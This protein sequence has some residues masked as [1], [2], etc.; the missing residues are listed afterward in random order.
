MRR[1]AF[2]FQPDRRSPRHVELHRDPGPR[3]RSLPRPVLGVLRT[4]GGPSRGQRSPRRRDVR[5]PR[6]PDLRPEARAELVPAR[7]PARRALRPGGGARPRRLPSGGRGRDRPRARRA[8]AR[9][10]TDRPR[11]RGARPGPGRPRMVQ[12]RL[13]EGPGRELDR[14][15]PAREAGAVPLGPLL[16][17]EDDG[18][19]SDSGFPDHLIESTPYLAR[20]SAGSCRPRTCFDFTPVATSITRS[21]CSRVGSTVAPQMIRAVGETFCWTT[22]AHR[23]ASLIVMSVPPVTL[24]RTPWAVEI[25]TS[26]RRELVASLIASSAR[27]S[28]TAWLSPIP[29]IATPPPFMIVFTSLKS[30]FT[31]PGF[32]MISVSPLI[33][34]IRV[35]SANRNARFRDI[36]GT[37][38]RSLSFGIVIT[39]SAVSRSRSSPH[40]ADSI[41]IF[42]SPRNGR[43]TTATV[44]APISFASRATYP[45]PPV[46]VP[47][48][49]PHVM[50]TMSEPWR[51][52]L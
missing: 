9:G 42:P 18:G 12:G 2:P 40:S 31:R 19:D 48:P 32:V 16:T 36:R 7:V 26:R 35:S 45:D 43:V 17:S 5:P 30:R 34:R 51:A 23:S 24:T 1:M 46:P 39:V 37:R 8:G 52:A 10:R 4:P 41:R 22:S 50:N 15:V 28:P 6:G 20:V 11:P 38:S 25:A 13:R 33:A 21:V 47:P 44:R 14:A 27:P 29:I 49:R 3:T